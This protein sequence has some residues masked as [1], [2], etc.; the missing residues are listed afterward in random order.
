MLLSSNDIPSGTFSKL[1]AQACCGDTDLERTPSRGKELETGIFFQRVFP[2][3]GHQLHAVVAD[4]Q[5]ALLLFV[6]KEDK[7][8]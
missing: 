8:R 2:Q 5:R 6:C 3:V 4:I 7:T 1:S